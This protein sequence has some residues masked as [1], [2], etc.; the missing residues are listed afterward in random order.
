M[1]TVGQWSPYQPP[2]I[3]ADVLIQRIQAYM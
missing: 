1:G 3:S 2:S